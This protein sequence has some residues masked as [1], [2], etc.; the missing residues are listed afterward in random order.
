MLTSI[1]S[2]A[3][4]GGVGGYVKT[5]TYTDNLEGIPNA[6]VRLMQDGEFIQ[7]RLTDI[8]GYYRFEEVEPGEYQLIFSNLGYEN[9]TVQEVRVQYGRITLVDIELEEE[10][11]MVETLDCLF[12]AKGSRSHGKGFFVLRRIKASS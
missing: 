3:Q 11:D 7:G 8:D 1:T 12:K 10:K 4:V 5:E 2:T 9:D 6:E